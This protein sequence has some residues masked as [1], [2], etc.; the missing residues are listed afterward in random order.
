MPRKYSVEFKEKAVHQIIEMVRLESCS[1]QRAYTEVGELLGVS[2]HTLRAWHRDSASVRDNSDASGGETMEEE[3]RRLRRENREL[4]RANGILKT[5]SAFSQRNSTDPRPNDLL[6]RRVQGSIWGRGHLQSS[7]QADRGFITSRGYRKA[8]TRVPSARALSDSLLIPEIQRVHA[9]NFSVY[10][11]RKMW[12]AMNRE[13]FHIGRDKTA[14][15]MKLAGVS[16][17]R[18]GRTPLTTIS[19]KAPDHR[20]DLVRRNFCAQALGRLWVADITYV[21]TLSGFAYTAFV[22]D[23]F[24]RKIV[25]VATRSTM[26]TDALP[27][28]AL[29]HALTTAGRIHGNQLIHHSDRGSQYVSLKY[30]TALA[31]SGIRPS[32]GT[33]GDSYDNALAETVNGLY[34]A[35]LIHAQGPWTSVGEVEL[36]TLR[37]VHWWNTKRLHE[38]LDYATPQEIETKYYLTEPIN[39]G[40]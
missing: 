17:R 27:M 7:K 3:L 18:R 35:E 23:V 30:S 4:K 15:L 14:R 37:W 21:R 28:E 34:K 13:G 10:G 29:E 36:A 9:E 8:T 25:G 16:G 11:I 19:P 33:V 12:H 39:T 2:H 22:V 38:A 5:A 24:S 31:E 40:P 6:H 32:V 20:P 26:R 1:L